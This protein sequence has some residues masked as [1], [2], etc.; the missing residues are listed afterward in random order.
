MLTL[1]FV[2][3]KRYVLAAPEDVA[4]EVLGPILDGIAAA[5]ADFVTFLIWF[6][7]W[8]GIARWWRRG[9]HR[10]VHERA[11][12]KTSDARNKK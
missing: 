5:L 8:W 1:C 11:C 12:Q 3:V 10:T 6:T 9:P 7:G 4:P 2:T